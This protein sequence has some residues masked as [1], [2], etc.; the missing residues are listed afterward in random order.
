MLDA[1]H[2]AECHNDFYNGKND[3]GVSVCWHLKDAQLVPRVLI[4]V[5]APPPYLKFK[6]EQVPQCYKRQRFVTVKPEAIGSDGY[7]A[8]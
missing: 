2:C 6:V 4:H 1:K 3:I 5:D 8:A 7:W